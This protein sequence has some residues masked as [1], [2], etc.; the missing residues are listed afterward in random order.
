MTDIKIGQLYISEALFLSLCTIAGYAISFSYELG[1]ISYFY[2]P[3]EL[4]SLSINV[5]LYRVFCVAAVLFVLMNFI[6]FFVQLFGWNVKQHYNAI[7]CIVFIVLTLYAMTKV[8]FNWGI[9]APLLIFVGISM[10]FSSPELIKIDKQP[11]QASDKDSSVPKQKTFDITDL[12]LKGLG[13]PLF[14]LLWVILCLTVFASTFGRIDASAEKDFYYF[15]DKNNLSTINVVLRLYNDKLIYSSLAAKPRTLNPEF[16]VL[17]YS[18]QNN[19]NLI[20]LKRKSIGPLVR[21]GY[22]D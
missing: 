20:A 4:I 19:S 1:Y 10:I 8:G 15:V 7:S 11:L 2:L 21:Q 22:A 18:C 14:F 12:L 17:N 6:Y 9:L 16:Y 3:M 13:A 5:I